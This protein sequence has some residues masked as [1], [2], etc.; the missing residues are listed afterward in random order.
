MAIYDRDELVYLKYDSVIDIDKTDFVVTAR[1]HF[2]NP[3]FS[4]LLYE[5]KSSKNEL[6]YLWYDKKNHKIIIFERLTAGLNPHDYNSL[7]KENL[8]AQVERKEGPPE[9]YNVSIELMGSNVNANESVLIQNR[10]GDLS[11]LK[12]T[13]FRPENLT[14]YPYGE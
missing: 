7:L 11:I 9:V 12:G 10:N 1:T 2:S 8:Q 4:Y 3:I 6:K 14:I 13:Y 5:M